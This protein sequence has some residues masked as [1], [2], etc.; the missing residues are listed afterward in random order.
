MLVGALWSNRHVQFCKHW[1]HFAAVSYSGWL[2]IPWAR[3]TKFYF[4]SVPILRSQLLSGVFRVILVNPF[5]QK[6]ATEGNFPADK[7]ALSPHV[8]YPK[9]PWLEHRLFL[10]TQV[11]SPFQAWGLLPWWGR[12]VRTAQTLPQQVTPAPKHCLRW[13]I[14]YAI[15]LLSLSSPKW[16]AACDQLFLSL[17]FWYQSI[18]LFKQVLGCFS[19]GAKII[20]SS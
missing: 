12:D 13:N 14:K 1:L 3:R 15:R 10:L 2:F 9:F 16:H 20:E 4:A 7:F 6:F 11:L 5:T 18:N 17:I 19:A 8:R